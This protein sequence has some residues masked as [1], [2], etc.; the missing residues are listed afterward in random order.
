MQVALT[1]ASDVTFTRNKGHQVL[2]HASPPTGNLV[3]VSPGVAAA[4]RF[5]WSQVEGYA[6]VLAQGTLLAGLPVQASTTIDGAVESVKRRLQISTTGS[7]LTAGT[8]FRAEVVDQD[9]SVTALFMAVSVS[10]AT[11]FDATG[12]IANNAPIVGRCVKANADTEEA[13]IDL[14]LFL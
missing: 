3:G 14:Q 5:Y 11:V 2:I 8:T 4:D 7:V 6:A 1:T 9:G 13:L 10:T 12:G